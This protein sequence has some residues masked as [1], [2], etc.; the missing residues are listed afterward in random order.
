M[1]NLPFLFIS[2]VGGAPAQCTHTVKVDPPCVCCER[3]FLSSGSLAIFKRFMALHVHIRHF[4]TL[5]TIAFIWGGK[6]W[7]CTYIQV[8][9]RT[10]FRPDESQLLIAN[11]VME[12]SPGFH[13]CQQLDTA[14]CCV[15]L[16]QP[17]VFDKIEKSDEQ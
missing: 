13:C 4:K 12:I 15:M 6:V 16:C 10:E 9:P 17:R 1:M 8:V 5:G 7:A 3:Y 2:G 11:D 14:N